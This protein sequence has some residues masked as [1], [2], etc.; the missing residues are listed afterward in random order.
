MS[1]SKLWDFIRPDTQ[2]TSTQF[3]RSIYPESVRY[4]LSYRGAQMGKLEMQ[5]LMHN[6]V[7]E[8]VYLVVK[9][10]GNNREGQRSFLEQLTR[11]YATPD[12]EHA[13]LQQLLRKTIETLPDDVSVTGTKLAQLSRFGADNWQQA[14][15]NIAEN[16]LHDE[17][18]ALPI[19]IAHTPIIAYH[20][21][22]ET[23]RTRLGTKLFML[24]PE[25]LMNPQERFMGYEITLSDP[26]TVKLQLRDECLFG[27]W[28][29]LKADCILQQHFCRK[30]IFIDDTI[31]TAA[32]IGKLQSFW[33]TEYGLNLPDDRVRCITDM[34]LHKAN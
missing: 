2:Q 11:L 22:I 24:I 33:H 16:L 4:A 29:C 10:L 25:L 8:T 20:Q 23:Y 34:R 1:I 5:A 15:R 28:A 19:I 18:Q 12:W 7:F 31:N 14:F 21:F 13:A 32:T 30:A 27:S 6:Y 3:Y 9:A 17:P 26:V